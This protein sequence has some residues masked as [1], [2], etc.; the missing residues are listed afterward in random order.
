VMLTLS[1]RHA[2]QRPPMPNTLPPLLSEQQI[3]DI[4]KVTRPIDQIKVWGDTIAFGQ[5]IESAT[6]TPLLARIAELEAL[7]EWQRVEINRL[8]SERD[9]LLAQVAATHTEQPNQAGDQ[10]VSERV[11]FVVSA[12]VIKDTA[13]GFNTQNKLYAVCAAGLDE[14]N[15]KVLPLL[16]VDFP[17]HRL[18]TM[19]S[20]PIAQPA[21]PKPVPMTGP[22]DLIRQLVGHIEV[23]TCTHDETH[24]GGAIWEICDACG[25]KWADDEGGMPAFEWPAIVEKAREYLSLRDPAA[26]EAHHHITSKGE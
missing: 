24:R 23:Q 16:A 8:Y 4:R 9:Q 11:D 12:V 3:I 14:A 1:L 13:T 15:G 21:P 22:D 2:K 17:Q 10:V 6:R 7:R 26:A 20:Y 25:E 19:C 18:H 5:A